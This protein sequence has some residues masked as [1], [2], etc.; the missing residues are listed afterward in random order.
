MSTG[1]GSEDVVDDGRMV[2]EVK[3]VYI[4]IPAELSA[5]KFELKISGVVRIIKK[6]C[7]VL[8]YIHIH[9]HIY[10]YICMYIDSR[11]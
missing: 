4:H 7:L 6:V 5:T 1:I 11:N 8:L 2:F 9:I 10:I 3:Q